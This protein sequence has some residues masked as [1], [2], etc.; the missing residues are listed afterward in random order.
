MISRHLF[1]NTGLIFKQ[2]TICVIWG[3]STYPFT[4]ISLMAVEE[5]WMGLQVDYWHRQNLLFQAVMSSGH[6]LNFGES[7]VA[8]SF[9]A[10]QTFQNGELA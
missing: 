8:D 9:T 7:T 5:V 4:K 3:Q 1:C 10:V 2:L 6:V